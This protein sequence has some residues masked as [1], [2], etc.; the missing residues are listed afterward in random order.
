MNLKKEIKTLRLKSSDFTGLGLSKPTILKYLKSP[1]LLVK[2]DFIKVL[3]E[4]YNYQRE[5]FSL[6]PI[7]L[8]DFISKLM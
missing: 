8:E 6:K 3:F 1:E 2:S 7:S 4:R 5:A